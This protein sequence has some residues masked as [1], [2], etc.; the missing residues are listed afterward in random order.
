[1]TLSV[2]TLSVNRLYRGV[3]EGPESPGVP[4]GPGDPG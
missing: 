2:M 3:P 1:M 4:E